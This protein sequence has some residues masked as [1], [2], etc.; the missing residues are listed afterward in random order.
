MEEALSPVKEP[1]ALLTEHCEDVAG[2]LGEDLRSSIVKARPETLHRDYGWTPLASPAEEPC[3]GSHS[4]VCKFWQI[5]LFEKAGVS[6]IPSLQHTSGAYL[7][8]SRSVVNTAEGGS[9][10]TVTH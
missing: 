4:A 1:E 7:E 6:A 5:G 2:I 8:L 10:R 9:A 3:R